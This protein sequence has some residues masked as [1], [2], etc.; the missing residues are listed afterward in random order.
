[1]ESSIESV[2]SS[3]DTGR[4][5][6]ILVVSDGRP[7][8]I[9][10]LRILLRSWAKV[11]GPGEAD[12]IRI[13]CPST[14]VAGEV[15]RQLRL[16][17]S[18]VI[19]CRPPIVSDDPYAIKLMIGEY[20]RQ[21][22]SQDAILL[23]I[24][25]DHLVRFPPRFPIPRE[26]EVFVSAEV[27]RNEWMQGLSTPSLS[28]DGLHLNTSLLIG[29]ASDFRDIAECWAET[30]IEIG[31]CVPIRW[32]EEVS[33]SV[34]AQKLGIILKPVDSSLQGHWND[35]QEDSCLF[36]YGGI[37]ESA[38]LARSLLDASR[39]VLESLQLHSV[40]DPF[41]RELIAYLLLDTSVD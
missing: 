32:Q 40:S 8:Q 11:I 15:R 21:A 22:A 26:R 41:L 24:D 25:Y 39:P 28:S 16:G 4:E 29:L 38:A 17:V 20:V 2:Y 35:W 3:V 23:Y 18:Q 34:A 31:Q 6:Q 1:M 13:L 12:Q 5:F 7:A 10:G 27:S 33:F 36:H 14:E 19:P 9:N 37:H 30:Y